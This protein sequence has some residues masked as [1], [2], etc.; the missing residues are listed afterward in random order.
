MACPAHTICDVLLHIPDKGGAPMRSPRRRPVALAITL[1]L[2]CAVAAC[3]NSKKEATPS[4]TTAPKAGGPTTAAAPG[5]KVHLE[6][7]PGVTDDEIQVAGIA[8]VTNPL[9]GKYE[10]A[11]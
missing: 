8:S 2:L 5:T 7:V 9:G 11:F 10:D 1:A 6:G 4:T 3:G